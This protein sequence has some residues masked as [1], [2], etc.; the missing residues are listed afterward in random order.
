M[1]T[2]TLITPIILERFLDSY[3]DDEYQTAWNKLKAFWKEFGNDPRLHQESAFDAEW[4]DEIFC[5]VLGYPKN[6]KGREYW[7]VNGAGRKEE[8]LDGLF[9]EKDK[10]TVK[11]IIELKS[12]DTPDL[13]KKKG[14]LS[15][16]TQG[17]KYLFQIQSSEMTV[18]SN[19]DDFIIFTRKEALRQSWS[20]KNINYDEFQEFYL[21]MSYNS[22]YKNLTQLMIEQ[23]TT[24]EKIIDDNFYS[25]VYSIH[26]SLHN[27]IKNPAHAND[28]FNKFLAMAIF[29]DSSDLP[30]ELIKTVYHRKMDFDQNVK[31]H[32]EVFKLF[33]QKMKNHKG[34]REYLG[35]NENISRLN[36]WQD[37]SYLGRNMIPKAILDMVLKMSEYNLKSVPLDVL[38][39]SIAERIYDKTSNCVYFADDDSHESGF[40]FYS[41]FLQQNDFTSPEIHLSFANGKSNNIKHHLIDLYNQI[42]KIQIVAS[43]ITDRMLVTDTMYVGENPWFVIVDIDAISDPQA[44]PIKRFLKYIKTIDIKHVDHDKN[45]VSYALLSMDAIDTGSITINNDNET[46]LIQKNQIDDRIVILTLKDREW[47]EKYNA[48]AKR[49]FDI[50]KV[51]PEQEANISFDMSDCEVLEKDEAGNWI[52]EYEW[53][54]DI[55]GESKRIYI[56]SDFPDLFVMLDSKDFENQLKF[57]NMKNLD[58]AVISFHLM[59][60]EFLSIAR[61]KKQI[62]DNIR[63]Y[64]FK[65]DNL[66]EKDAPEAEIIKVEMILETLYGQVKELSV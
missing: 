27:C 14:A 6:L 31:S 55:L 37:T 32:W 12:L 38:F 50:A 66:K 21:V 20:L 40:R 35:I 61:K 8:R 58:K 13:F 39:Y 16:V 56:K 28:L 4:I 5:G 60:E 45:V 23:T 52:V 22:V 15:P 30:G 64:E 63:L 47:L 3:S 34:S 46:Y 7:I 51:V 10:Q 18:V 9:Y 43:E 17:A 42:S 33:F 54:H 24:E 62:Q 49:L 11:M 26:K 1:N 53:L 29:E 2:K 65:I 57:Q 36:V 59:G 19:F 48:G 41:T 25:L 44:T